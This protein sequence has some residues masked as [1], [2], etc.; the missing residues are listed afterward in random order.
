[1]WFVF[2]NQS[3]YATQSVTSIQD[4]VEVAKCDGYEVIRFCFNDKYYIKLIAVIYLTLVNVLKTGQLRRYQK[5]KTVKQYVE[6]L[7]E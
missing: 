6:M 5:W 7:C 4:T 1:M 2:N 3:L